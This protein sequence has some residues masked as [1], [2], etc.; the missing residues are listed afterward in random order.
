MPMSITLVTCDREPV[1]TVSDRQV[2]A[3]LVGRGC[4]VRVASWTDPDVDWT[5]SACTVLRSLWD[6][7]ARPEGFLSWLT[8]V[9]RQTALVNAPALVRWNFDKRCLLALEAN[10]VPVI[11]THD[12]ERGRA[13]AGWTTPWDE[14]VVKPVIGASSVGVGQFRLPQQR[15]HFGTHRSSIAA[16][17]AERSNREG[18]IAG[19]HRGRLFACGP[20]HSIQFG[21]DAGHGRVRPQGQRRGNGAGPTGTC[22]GRCRGRAVCAR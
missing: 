18:E 17:R 12:W 10:G 2:A 16:L 15:L 9:E 22:C 13:I 3:E 6:A 1:L 5:A 8:L 20:A 4:G 14:V 19:F 7:S 11:S 21:I